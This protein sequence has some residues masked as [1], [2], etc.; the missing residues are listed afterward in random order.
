MG[1][2]PL[3]I[4][5]HFSVFMGHRHSSLCG[6]SSPFTNEKRPATRTDR[7]IFHARSVSFPS[8][9]GTS[10]STESIHRRSSGKRRQ[11]KSGCSYPCYA[12]ELSRNGSSIEEAAYNQFLGDFP[13]YRSTWLIDALRMSEYSRLDSQRETYVDYMGGALFPESLVH[14]HGEFLVQNVLGNTHSVSNRYVYMRHQMM[15]SI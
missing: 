7:V 5:P 2:A 1:R 14:V 9:I 3:V 6:K 15:Y 4:S 13:Q 11:R 12:S 10:S 8:K